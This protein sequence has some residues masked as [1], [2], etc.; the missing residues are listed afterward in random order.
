MIQTDRP[1]SIERARLRIREAIVA[2]KHQFRS[3]RKRS[4]TD[5]LERDY[6]VLIKGPGFT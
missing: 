2:G 3:A 1:L 5:S 4:R 6:S